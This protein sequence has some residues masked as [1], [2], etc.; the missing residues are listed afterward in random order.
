MSK[1]YQSGDDPNESWDK[2]WASDRVAACLDHQQPNYSNF[3]QTHWKDFFA[4]LARHSRVL[5]IGTGNGAIAT[6]ANEISHAETLDFDIHGIDTAN[7]D[8]HK[9]VQ[10]EAVLLDGITFHAQT[11]AENTP[12]ADAFFQAVCGQYAL[13]YTAIENTIEELA[14]ITQAGARLRFILHAKSSIAVATAQTDLDQCR[15][16]LEKTKILDKAQ[17]MMTLIADIER[18]HMQATPAVDKEALQ[19]IKTFERAA[20]EISAALKQTARKSMYS[21][22]LEVTIK[23]HENR[24]KFSKQ[25][26]LNNVESLRAEV[27]AHRGRLQALV[28]NAKDPTDMEDIV[29]MLERYGLKHIATEAVVD[30][31]RDKQFGWRLDAEKE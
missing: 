20:R 1:R 14:R 31:Q 13:E 3:I 27:E 19:R 28:G 9:F 4:G 2:Y 15:L 6:I 18:G 26:I 29:V 12:F 25:H 5:D 11:A 30:P 7:I 21:N 22:V 24:R 16:L 10:H 23:T 17:D 8:P